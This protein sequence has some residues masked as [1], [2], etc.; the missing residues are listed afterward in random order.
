MLKRIVEQVINI[1]LLLRAYALWV[2]ALA[3]LAGGYAF[4]QGSDILPTIDPMSWGTSPFKFGG[5]ILLAIAAIKRASEQQQFKKYGQITGN[6][7]VWRG[8]ALLL[9]I[10]G[11]FGLSIANYGAELVLFGLVSPWTTVLFGVAS[12]LV[13]MGGRDLLKQA[14][15]WIGAPNLPGAPVDMTPPATTDPAP[16]SGFENLLPAGF[17]PDAVPAQ[18]L[19]FFGGAIGSA[20]VEAT[21]GSLLEGVLNQLHL[22]ATADNIAH[23]ALKLIKVFPDLADG[24]FHLNWRNRADILD[25][26]QELL[27]AGGLK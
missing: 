26:T 25:A 15:G 7:W 16:P 20:V 14:L 21:L 9:G 22:P 23:L 10:G 4:A 6:P 18:A 17:T 1:L 24:D 12:A 2:L 27:A 11:A 3:L 8:L 13:A 5:F 19:P